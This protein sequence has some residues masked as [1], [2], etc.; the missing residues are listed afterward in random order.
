MVGCL[1]VVVLFLT[2]IFVSVN[3]S[4]YNFYGDLIGPS[5]GVEEKEDQAPQ[6]NVDEGHLVERASGAAPSEIEQFPVSKPLGQVAGLAFTPKGKLLAFH[7][8]D[9]VWDEFSFDMNFKFNS[10]LSAIKNS[11]FYLIDPITG[12]VEA[13]HGENMFYMPH[14]VTVDKKGNI[15]VTDVGSHQVMKLD[16]D[17]KPVMTLGEKMVPG[18][19][20]K[21]FCQPTDVAVLSNGDFFVADG[22][23]NSRIMK[24]DAN[25]KLLTSFGAPTDEFPAENG[26]FFVPHSLA[27]IEDLNLICVADRENERVQCFSAGI[28]EGH[29]PTVP[30]GV[31]ITK[32]ENI[33]RVYAIREKRHYLIGVT[34]ADFDGQIEPQVFVMDMD[35][36]K[37]NTFAKGIENAHTLA[38]SEDG[39][40][41]I[42][43]IGPNQILKL[44]LADNQ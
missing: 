14:G 5:V 29:R 16:K 35:T 38:V 4:L 12:T 42:G 32:A 8:G 22:Y 33:G 17:F 21:H 24:F 25:G 34:G 7:R 18:S 2:L 9:R 31:F 26:E 30:N 23:C 44:A 27:L 3:A 13:E 11:T 36:G 15:W 10:T 41:F 40:V 28:S 1:K 39:H 6:Q 19:D 43:L 37:A 20:E